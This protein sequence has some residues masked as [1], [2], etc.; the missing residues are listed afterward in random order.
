MSKAILITNMPD[1]CWECNF[2]T[3]DNYGAY[4]CV[5]M[6]E[7]VDMYYNK[8]KHPKCPLLPLLEEP[9]YD[10]IEPKKLFKEIMNHD[11]K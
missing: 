5:A 11:D 2:C 7:Y 3:D 10:F 8:G 6:N 1:K 4:I 9:K